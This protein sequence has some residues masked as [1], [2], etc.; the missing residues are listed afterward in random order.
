MD[1]VVSRMTESTSLRASLYEVPVSI[2]EEQ[3]I[4]DTPCDDDQDY[5]PIYCEPPTEE[6]KLY[7]VFEG[8]TL[9]KLCYKDIRYTYIYIH[10]QLH[11]YVGVVSKHIIATVHMYSKLY[12]CLYIYNYAC[13]G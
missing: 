12:M 5:G 3:N 1:Q 6:E 10:M 9:L 11:L 7:A 8:K 2:E 4:Y 13:A